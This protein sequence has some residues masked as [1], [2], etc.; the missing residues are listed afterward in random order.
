MMSPKKKIQSK[1]RRKL[2]KAAAIKLTAQQ[3]KI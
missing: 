3:P 1:T 2:I